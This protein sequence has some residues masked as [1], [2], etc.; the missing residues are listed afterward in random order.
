MN[1]S[2]IS[3]AKLKMPH[4]NSDQGLCRLQVENISKRD[5]AII[6][7]SCK[8]AEAEDLD[9]Y[10]NILSS[11]KECIR[12]IP[13]SRKR[14]AEEYFRVFKAKTG[15]LEFP[16]K[17]Y[18]NEIDKFDY[19]FFG[20]S[21]MEANLMDPY[22]RV[23]LE[24]AWKTIEDSGY[25][26]KQLRGT[27]TGIFLGISND[28]SVD[29]YKLIEKADSSL[30][31]LSIAGNIRSVIASRLAY[32]MDLKGP[33]IV[34]D[35][36]CSSSLVAI[37]MACQSIRNGECETALAGG[38]KLL[39]IANN[40]C[41]SDMDVGIAS[42]DEKTRTFDDSSDGT[43]GGEGVAAI[44]LKP[45]DKAICDKDN[46]YAVIKGSAVN[47]DGSSVGITAPNVLAQQQVILDAWKDAKIDPSTISLME[48]HGTGTKLGDP[49]EIS[50]IQEAFNKFT[51][52]K[53]FCA[54]GS[55]KTNIGHLDNLSGTAGLIKL[56]MAMKNKKL[57]PSLNF[58][59][60]NRNIN[61]CS[62]PV[63][64]NDRLADWDTDGIPRR[65]GVSSFGLSGTNCHVVLEE[66][67]QVETEE[68]KDTNI[69]TLS[70]KTFEALKELAVSYIQ[71][72][73]RENK[74]RLEDICYTVNTGRSHY[75][76]RLAIVINSKEELVR[77]LIEL[78]GNMS[79]EVSI[80][81]CLESGEKINLKLQSIADKYCEGADINFHEIYSNSNF[82]RVSLPTYPFAR[83]RAWI[84]T[85]KVSINE[86]FD[87]TNE[88]PL[89]ERVAIKSMD[90]DVYC[91][92]YSTQDYW[93]L[94][95]HAINGNC[96][97]PG[98][99][100]VEIA[101]ALGRK[102]YGSENN[103]SLKNIVF[104]KPLVVKSGEKKEVQMI[105]KSA[106]KNFEFSIISKNEENKW[107]RHAEGLIS[108]AEEV[109][110]EKYDIDNLKTSFDKVEKIDS[111]HRKKS[112][113]TVSGRWDCTK[114]IYS[115]DNSVLCEIELPE[116][117]EEDLMQYYLHP[118]LLDCAAN[119]ANETLGQGLYLPYSYKEFKIYGP[120]PRKFYSYILKKNKEVGSVTAAF[121]IYLLN[122]AGDVFG[123]INNYIVKKVEDINIIA[124]NNSGEKLYHSMKWVL[125]EENHYEENKCK[126]VLIF[127]DSNGLAD[128]VVTNLKAVNRKVIE[129]EIGENYSRLDD[130]KF[131]IRGIEE[132]YIRLFNEVKSE[133][134]DQIVHMLSI[135][136]NESVN[137][138]D[139]LNSKLVKGIDS[140]FYII[141]ALNSN[142]TK[143]KLELVLVG[144]HAYKVNEMDTIVNP[145]TA[146]FFAMGKAIEKEHSKITVKCIDINE[147]ISITDILKE[148]ISIRR[149]A[150]VSY[151]GK[152]KY[153]QQ[154]DEVS[155]LG[156]K[157]KKV[158]IKE[159]GVYVI[160]GG[161]GGI[162]MEFV[163]MLS[164]N[165]SVKLALIGRT[166]K[167]SEEKLKEIE[168]I[169]ET[170]AELSYYS[171]DVSNEAELKLIFEEIRNKYGVI[172]GVFHAAGKA[173]N[174]FLI[175]KDKKEFDEVLKPKIQG[176]FILDK[177][178][179]EDKLDFFI[180]FSSVTALEG[181]MGQTD[182]TAAN[183]YL[184][185]FA[186]LVNLIKP[187]QR[188]VAINWTAWS[189]AGM[190][191]DLKTDLGKSL[192]KPISTATAMKA[193]RGI[194][195]KDIST[196]VIGEIDHEK[197][198]L[199]GENLSF[200][201]DRTIRDVPQNKGNLQT[202]SNEIN[203][204]VK[205]DMAS[206]ENLVIRAWSKILG[207]DSLG[208]NEKFYDIGGDSI[209]AIYL[210]KELDKYFPSLLDVSDIFTYPSA[211]GIAQYIKE[212]LYPQKEITEKKYNITDDSDE[213][214]I[215][216]SK[217]ASGE[218]D[219]SEVDKLVLN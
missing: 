34:V 108:T 114:K 88:H 169:R 1:R 162:G 142:I 216:L 20:I 101:G 173:G 177:L 54:I 178:T 157:E 174:G 2:Y 84:D 3:L 11:G 187:K 112:T 126:S 151:R 120:T 55:V 76:H 89:I 217:I 200:Y 192:F 37:H 10:W 130:S 43:N 18:M 194:M 116:E 109:L 102:Y 85:S 158:K 52:K 196:V 56:V 214:D 59:I 110:A 197:L 96:L 213:L 19:G 23:F 145:H 6:G 133:K 122:E 185:S 131:V 15:N 206:I 73:Q 211:E 82:R 90:M 152:Q 35:T 93:V 153:I 136:N 210:V 36:A 179:K 67:P 201:T 57:I 49:I 166:N 105:V 134:Y 68:V 42:S 156:L 190:A 170:G 8:F 107:V 175:R 100:Y 66:A 38:I 60:P 50:A 63:Y 21:P 58:K 195:R 204:K 53:Q 147:T 44:L 138:V 144:D 17:A 41:K 186:Q 87:I 22:Q 74:L 39:T 29:Y 4:G 83:K 80:G 98:T 92:N 140:L 61:F 146:A 164:G 208:L 51:D 155:L 103:I 207:V 117:F 183:A 33:A 14:D 171:A 199:E 125:E 123:E 75:K 71:F 165:K 128:K 205:T 176:T 172:N 118:S 113:I 115:N 148:I 62:S 124:D 30:L 203:C 9:S 121:N 91:T 160:T 167:L 154:L 25:G 212:T 31:G 143:G 168:E 27:K 181:C 65:C 28:F 139:K 111:E 184:D 26:G 77:K 69:F 7:I 106:G 86:N 64:V 13:E 45:L 99:A 46:I 191:F 127:K 180:L 5:I 48:A 104:A 137:S 70:A 149:K 198:M 218:I 78:I 132:D 141:K 182:Y 163:R 16:R 202:Q 32:I 161:A 219:A 189:E 129:V 150:L 81:N 193:F 95:D 94:R 40:I 209:T 79:E 24:T 159:A 72:L 135:D 97:L 188:T 215:I 47:Q 119:G 12:A